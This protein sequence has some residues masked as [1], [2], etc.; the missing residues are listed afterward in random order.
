MEDQEYIIRDDYLE[1]G[2]WSYLEAEE[3]SGLRVTTIR[4]YLCRGKFSKGNK[5]GPYRIDADSFIDFVEKGE[6]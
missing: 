2:K 6:K 5:S 4:S 1:K 3:W